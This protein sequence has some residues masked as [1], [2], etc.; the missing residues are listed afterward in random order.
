MGLLP[1]THWQRANNATPS[2][3]KPSGV[4]TL[5]QGLM[6]SCDPYFWHI[7]VDLFNNN[8]AADITNMARAFGLGSPTGIGAV[9][10]A[11]GNISVPTTLIQATNQVIGQGDVQVTPLQVARFVAAVGNGGTLYTPQ[12]IQEIQS[13]DGKPVSVFKPEAAGTLPIQPDRLAAIQ[14]AMQWVISDPRGTAYYRMQGL[15]V[16]MG[17]KTGTAQTERNTAGCVV[18]WIYPRS[19]KFP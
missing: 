15:T 11:S 4:I 8:R 7:S 17:G 10:E 3:T 2:Q 13:A 1:A 19:A 18:R 16:P 14:Q 6:R 9:A 12:L 5:Q